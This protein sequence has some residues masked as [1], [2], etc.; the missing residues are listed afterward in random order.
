[1]KR[2]R[3]GQSFLYRAK[4]YGSTVIEI[5]MKDRISGGPIQRALSSCEKRFPYLVR[6]LVEKN[7]VY[8]LAPDYNSMVAAC[9]EK[10]RKLGSM[11]TGYHLVDVTFFRN[12]I[13]VSFHHGL[14]DGKGILPFVESLLY[15][16]CSFRY[17]KEFSS[18]GI[19]VLGQVIAPEED[20]EP[21][22]HDYLPFDDS[23]VYNT[24]TTAFHLPE[25]VADPSISRRTEFIMDENRFVSAA[26]GVGATPSLF[27]AILIS[28]AL[29]KLNMDAG[30]P[31]MCNLAMDMRKVLGI[32]K[33]HCNCISTAYLPF[34]ASDLESDMKT[35]AANYRKLLD[36][37][38]EDNTVKTNVNRQIYLYNKLDGLKSL[39][40]KRR[41]M[42]FFDKMINDT[43]VLSYLGR[44][45]LNDCNQYVDSARF[46]N[47]AVSGLVVN[48]LCAGG[49][50]TIDVLQGF[51]DT[52]YADAIHTAIEPYGL[53][54]SRSGMILSTAD[55]KGHLTAS[56]QAERLYAKTEED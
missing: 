24:D 21:F 25:A 42:A 34:S 43:Y 56:R 52:K 31:V 22:A 29:Q 54:E 41:M 35:I 20:R 28:C 55:D 17:R 1:M 11:A 23:K 19:R 9:T 4:G 3:S 46:Y 40:E 49:R 33:T 51:D 15:Y 39:D 2:I 38:R 47:N 7:G 13:R 8:Y 14:C 6:K 37:Q 44:L 18:D 10:F 48:M 50:M 53:L 45:K 27:A 16:Y 30:E 26:K 5:K 36:R 32:E 12:I